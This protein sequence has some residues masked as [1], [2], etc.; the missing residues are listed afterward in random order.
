MP[1]SPVD[2][3]VILVQLEATVKLTLY[4]LHVQ[5]S[6]GPDIHGLHLQLLPDPV[7]ANRDF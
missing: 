5:L 1:A 2:Y 3:P 6:S 7:Y 4:N